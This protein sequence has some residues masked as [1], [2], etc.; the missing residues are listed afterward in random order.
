[1]KKLLFLLFPLFVIAQSYEIEAE[2]DF[3]GAVE[4]TNMNEIYNQVGVH[5]VGNGYYVSTAI[6]RS[7]VQNMALRQGNAFAFDL[8]HIAEMSDGRIRG[9]YYFDGR[10]YKFIFRMVLNGT[11]FPLLNRSEA[12]KRARENKELYELGLI[13]RQ[14]FETDLYYIKKILESQ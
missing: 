11:S 10:M 5:Y 12:I 6:S 14:K 2:I 3:S 7:G 9:N 8:N 4:I 1:M 13:G